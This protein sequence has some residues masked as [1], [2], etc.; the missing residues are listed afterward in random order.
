MTSGIKIKEIVLGTGTIAE[1]PKIAVI[2]VRAF[3]NRG[4]EFWN[5]YGEGKPVLLHLSERNEIPGLVK[6]IEGMRVGGK[7][8]LVVSPHRA[9]GATGVSGK[10]PAN[11]VIRFEVELVE[12]RDQNAPCPETHPPGR[13]LMVFHPGEQARNLARWQFAISEGQSVGGAFI[14]FPVPGA[15]WRHAR[16]KSVELPLGSEQVQ[17]L[18]QSVQSKCADHPTECLRNDQMWADASEKANSVTRDQATDTLCV[19]VYIQERGAV[20]LDYGLPET[21]LVLLNS[22]FYQIISSA[23]GPHLMAVANEVKTSYQARRSGEHGR[24]P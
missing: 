11:A 18:F 23:L 2:H 7:R 8:E 20:V 15:T 1:R 21:S 9:F 24:L 13:H 6:G 17:E 4:D 19:T 14:T 10:I 12:V 22:R 16:G 5:T 3:L